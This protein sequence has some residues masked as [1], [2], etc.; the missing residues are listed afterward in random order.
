M[1]L[2]VKWIWRWLVDRYNLVEL[3]EYPPAKQS[4]SLYWYRSYTL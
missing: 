2:L 4:R 1:S 3:Y